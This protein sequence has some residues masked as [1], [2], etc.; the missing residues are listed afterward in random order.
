[1]I[2]QVPAI[3]SRYVLISFFIAR[4][5]GVLTQRINS[6]FIFIPINRLVEQVFEF[7]EIALALLF[8]NAFISN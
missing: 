5:T 1:M 7:I 2:R 6:I 3:T 8:L 4:L